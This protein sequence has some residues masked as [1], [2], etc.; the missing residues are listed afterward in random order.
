MVEEMG[1]TIGFE[2][3]PGQGATFWLLFDA[4]ES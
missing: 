4:I 1:G 2:S 3:E